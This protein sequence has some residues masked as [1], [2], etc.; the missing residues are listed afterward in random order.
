MI[1]FLA[2]ADLT[3]AIV[4]GCRRQE[5]TLDF[6]SAAEARLEGMPDHEV[7][8][9]AAA[10]IRILVTHDRHTMPRHFGEFLSAQGSCPGVFLVSQYAP[11]GEIIDELV[12][13]WAASEAHEWKNRIV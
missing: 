3:H 2:D 12:L 13:I 4:K 1:R 11:I 6:L 7:L 5:P 9:F 10:E 8:A